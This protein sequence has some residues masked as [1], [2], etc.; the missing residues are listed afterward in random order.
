M[1]LK[2][3]IIAIAVLAMLAG[4]AYWA[5][6]KPAST[7]GESHSLV[8]ENLL[9][10]EIVQKTGHIEASQKDEE[11][12]IRLVKNED[13]KWVLPDYHGMPVN[14][15]KLNGIIKNLKD[16]EVFRWVTGK[17]ERAADLELG[18]NKVILKS[19][20][21]GQVL[22]QIETGK[23]AKSGGVFIRLGEKEDV[24]LADAN[25]YV[26]TRIE[27]WAD[28]KILEF[29]KDDVAGL[30]IEF[31][32]EPDSFTISR[33]SKDDSFTSDQ[34]AADE[35]I[36]ESEA[37]RVINSLINARFNEVIEDRDGP[38]AAGARENARAFTLKLF[39]GD[40]Y[41]LKIGR[42]PKDWTP[43]EETPSATAEAPEPEKATETAKPGEEAK[44]ETQFNE[45]GPVCIFYECNN[46]EFLWNPILE[47]LV[48]AFPD[49]VYNNLPESRDILTEKK[50][51][52]QPPRAETEPPETPR[53]MMDPVEVA[54]DTGEPA[55][56]AGPAEKTE[57]PPENQPE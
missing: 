13:G 4:L 25:L 16:A 15:N 10:A 11:N 37:A 31:P 55:E 54:P 57:T 42:R 12:V 27:N 51:Q 53:V 47:K 24:Y 52:P 35:Q 2:P 29:T 22:W 21:E 32:E 40:V 30:T 46:P 17:P 19:S 3:L 48:L 26:D 45:P 18:E 20:P 44:P 9:P 39:D 28:K 14:F 23:R 7:D 6:H 1:K 5:R 56:A 36:K 50:Q 8:G 33:G 34:L 38:D 41:T 49:Y 43:P